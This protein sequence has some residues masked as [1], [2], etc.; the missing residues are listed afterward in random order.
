MDTDEK[1]INDAAKRHLKCAL[2]T[3]WKDSSSTLSV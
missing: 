2:A 1:A 3:D